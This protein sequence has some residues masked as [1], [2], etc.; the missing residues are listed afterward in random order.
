MALQTITYPGVNL[1]SLGQ[2]SRLG[3]SITSTMDAVGES[4]TY[5]GK[6]YLEGGSG[7]K[8]ISSSGGKILWRTGSLITFANAATNFRIGI[9]DVAATGLEDGTFDV[10]ADLTS[11]SGIVG[12]THYET[13][14]TSGSKTIT[15]GDIIAISFE[16]TARGGSDSVS[17]FGRAVQ[18]SAATT[19]N[20]PYYT[21]DTGSGPT[22]T[23][24]GALGAVILFDDGSLGWIDQA[25]YIPFSATSTIT[26][27][28]NSS[29][30]EYAAVF[31]LPYKCSISGGWFQL[32]DIASTDTFEVI[33][34]SSPD[35]SP[36][37]QRTSTIDPNLTGSTTT[38]TRYSYLF[39]SSYTLSANTWYGISMRPTSAN[40]LTLGYLDFGSTLG[41]KYKKGLPFGTN[42]KLS[43]RTN[44]S[45]AF[46]EVQTYYQ[47]IFGVTL[48]K[49][50]DGLGG[51]SWAHIG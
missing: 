41:S 10:Y 5:I 7:S 47:P 43:S 20:F 22:R 36:V 28:L 44:Q 24:T 6:C 1:D 4:V 3:N 21:T 49:L 13:A 27:G 30:D 2:Y 48:D 37:A 39:S 19:L 33:L 40:T 29:P 34:Y 35:T 50:D 38:T 31:K 32:G 42:C 17:Q 45:G 14:M 9:Q 23:N 15:H 51:G 16:M 18:Y 8:T 12:T 26:Y 11:S 46:T 25:Y